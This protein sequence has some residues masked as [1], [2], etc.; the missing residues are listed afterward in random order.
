MKLKH[1]HKFYPFS[2]GTMILQSGNYVEKAEDK[3]RVI[4]ACECGK[5]KEVKIK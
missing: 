1:K 5:I 2:Y 3:E 4:F